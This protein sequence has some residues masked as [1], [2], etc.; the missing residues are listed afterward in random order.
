MFSEMWI[1]K[2]NTKESFDQKDYIKLILEP[3][4]QPTKEMLEEAIGQFEKQNPEYLWKHVTIHIFRDNNNADI[5]TAI[6]DNQQT[7]EEIKQKLNT[8]LIISTLDVAKE[9]IK[10]VFFRN[11]FSKS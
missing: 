11:K 10:R 7:I 2:T 5:A 9:A 4:T 1:N 3:G 8:P 6:G